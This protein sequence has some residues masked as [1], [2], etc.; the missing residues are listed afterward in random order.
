[1]QG[2]GGA[3]GLQAAMAVAM[4]QKSMEVQA[5]QG[6]VIFRTL[7]ETAQAQAQAEALA[8]ASGKGLKVDRMV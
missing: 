1:M 6:S 2:I 8:H 4:Q 7:E 3:G 5:I